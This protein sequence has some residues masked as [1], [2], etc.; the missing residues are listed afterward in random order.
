MAAAGS[1]LIDAETRLTAGAGSTYFGSSAGPHADHRP[2]TTDQPSPV[3]DKVKANL[4]KLS[5]ADRKL[6]EAQR[7]CPVTGEPLGSMGKPIK[8]AVKGE[9]VFVCCKGCPDDALA[10]PDKT[11]GKIKEFR[12][13]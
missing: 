8:L 9:T 10:H 6:A 12:R 4:G 3:T 1:F 5:P 2:T 11:L 13:K 7:L